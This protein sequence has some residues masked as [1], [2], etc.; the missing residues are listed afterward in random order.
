M[1]ATPPRRQQVKGNQASPS[2]YWSGR[3]VKEITTGSKRGNS[4]LQPP[5][6]GAIPSKSQQ[7]PSSFPLG[8]STAR[9][10]HSGQSQQLK[11]HMTSPS[12]PDRGE[13]RIISKSQDLGQPL[14]VLPGWL[15]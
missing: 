12:I 9:L 3:V 5:R 4:I 13:V 1:K 14:Y 8:H 6:S 2:L 10:V 11:Y 15:E 7:A